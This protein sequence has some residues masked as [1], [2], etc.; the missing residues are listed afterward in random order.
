[1]WITPE[2]LWVIGLM[3][4]APILGYRGL[5]T[6]ISA[7]R[8]REDPKAP[9][10]FYRGARGIIAAIALVTIAAGLW[11]DSEAVFLFGVVFLAEEVYET[12]MAEGVVRWGR[13]REDASRR[14]EPTSV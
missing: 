4:V 2:I 10:A 3:T 8:H 14:S 1:M 5:R 6:L 7:F 11:F 9:E 13:K 12:L